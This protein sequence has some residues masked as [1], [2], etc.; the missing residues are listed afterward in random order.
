MKK[1]LKQKAVPE[2]SQDWKANVKVKDTVSW[3]LPPLNSE[4]IG[5]AI[6]NGKRV[7]CDKILN[8]GGKIDSSAPV[9]M[10]NL[11]CSEAN[12]SKSIK[13]ESNKEE[14]FLKPSSFVSPATGRR[15]HESKVGLYDSV[16]TLDQPIGQPEV[17]IT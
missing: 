16:N 8:F 17:I 7:F 6:I 5:S 10:E 11:K 12:Y 13:A 4:T 3:R 2:T 14:D 15:S 9:F 1:N